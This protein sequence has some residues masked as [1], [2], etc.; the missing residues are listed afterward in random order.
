[1]D[2]RNREELDSEKIRIITNLVVRSRYFIDEYIY[3]FRKDALFFLLIIILNMFDVSTF[4]F[5]AENKLTEN[6]SPENSISENYEISTNNSYETKDQFKVKLYKYY[7]VTNGLL[8]SLLFLFQWLLYYIRENYVIL[9]NFYIIDVLLLVQGVYCVFLTIVLLFAYNIS[10]TS[11]FIILMNSLLFISFTLR[12]FTLKQYN[13]MR[14][15]ASLVYK[16]ISDSKF[17]KRN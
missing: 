10:L 3:C 13:V 12:Y 16:D 15:Q 7:L 6:N 1:M 8:L 11:I 4:S 14:N 5:Y 17:N 2:N 9:I